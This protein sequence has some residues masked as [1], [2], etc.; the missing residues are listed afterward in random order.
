MENELQIVSEE[1]FQK[2]NAPIKS[3]PPFTEAQLQQIIANQSNN[4]DP[5]MVNLLNREEKKKDLKKS[6]AFQK[7]RANA[8]AAKQSRKINRK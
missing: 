2:L 1:E 4:L 3:G 6:K 7:R 5:R 8:K